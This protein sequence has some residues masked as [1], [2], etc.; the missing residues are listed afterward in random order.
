MR[1]EKF[2]LNHHLST[3]VAIQGVMYND[4]LIE[5]ILYGILKKLPPNLQTVEDGLN[6][7]L[8]ASA[9]NVSQYPNGT[10]CEQL[11]NCW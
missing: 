4:T 2:G 1:H 3:I 7:I 5:T 9:V 11:Q 10:G 6:T 8:I